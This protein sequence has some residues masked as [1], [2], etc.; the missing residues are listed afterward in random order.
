MVIISDFKGQLEDAEAQ[1]RTAGKSKI[2]TLEGKW[3]QAE[4]DLEIEI[5]R[6]MDAEKVNLCHSFNV[7][8]YCKPLKMHV[9]KYFFLIGLKEG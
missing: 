7:I 8:I 1:A 5:K 6:R 2:A 4:G 3:R 9:S